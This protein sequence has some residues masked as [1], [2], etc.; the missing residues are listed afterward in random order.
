MREI[1]PRRGDGPA[2]PIDGKIC[3]EALVGDI[4]ES[5]YGILRD[6]AP[7]NAAPN[8]TSLELACKAALRALLEGLEE[9]AFLET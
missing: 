7:D 4:E 3:P 8:A 9:P 5:G 6:D 2:L 1:L